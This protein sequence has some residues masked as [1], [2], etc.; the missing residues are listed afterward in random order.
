MRKTIVH[1][2]VVETTEL[3]WIT[4]QFHTP[5]SE[6]NLRW[7]RRTARALHMD[8]FGVSMT[9]EQAW[10][11]AEEMAAAVDEIVRLRR[12]LRRLTR[13]SA[14]QTDPHSLG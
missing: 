3:H 13:S 4:T 12:R 9:E 6:P 2:R 10:T 7:M 11:L 1:P 14:K 8:S 5:P